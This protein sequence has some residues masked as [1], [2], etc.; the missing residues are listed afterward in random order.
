MLTTVKTAGLEI[1]NADTREIRKLAQDQRIDRDPGPFSLGPRKVYGALCEDGK[2]RTV[3]CSP[4][5]ADT[6]FSIPASV[7]ANGKTVSGY[8]TMSTVDGYSTASDTD[9]AIYR[10]VVY[11]YGKN[12]DR[13]PRERWMTPEALK[14]TE[15][16]ERFLT[17]ATPTTD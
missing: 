6:F 1:V 16:I 10:F 15:D 9:P 5:G 3:R 8:L 2:Q 7:K 17:G 14:V 13:I 12:A 4:N 11:R